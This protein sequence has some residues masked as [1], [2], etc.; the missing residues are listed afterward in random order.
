MSRF[1]K[2]LTTLTAPENAYISP[3]MRPINKI[4]KLPI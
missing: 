4:T 2:F 3:Y 1:V